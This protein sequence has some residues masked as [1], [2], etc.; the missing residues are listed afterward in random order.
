[1]FNFAFIAYID[2]IGSKR[3]FRD[4]E[5][6]IRII[7]IFLGRFLQL[8][9]GRVN[10][11]GYLL[12]QLLGVVG[13][14]LIRIFNVTNNGIE[15]IFLLLPIIALLVLLFSLTVRRLHDIGLSGWFILL[16]FFPI[17]NFIMTIFF[18]Q[19]FPGQKKTNKYGSPPKFG[20]DITSL[21]GLAK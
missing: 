21:L 11:L 13:V 7:G 2:T 14:I 5:L 19:L 12:A 9:Q 15:F 1:M 17:F 10:R 16:L 20:V 18:L 6:I 8:F 3:T 4:M